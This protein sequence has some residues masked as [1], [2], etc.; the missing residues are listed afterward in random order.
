MRI[1]FTIADANLK[2]GTE[3][4]AFN[5]LHGLNAEGIVYNSSSF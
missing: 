1:L 5:L 3:I 2:G 4:L